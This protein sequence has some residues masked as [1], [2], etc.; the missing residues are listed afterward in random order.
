V[1]LWRVTGDERYLDG[2]RF[3]LE[4]RG[5]AHSVAAFRFDA[6][7]PF[8]IYNDLAYRQDHRPVVEQTRAVGHAVRATYMF[9]GMT[10]VATLLGL[11]AWSETLRSVWRDVTDRR[12]YLTGGLGSQGRT[13]AFGDDY[14][15]PNRRAYAE[16]CAS[17]GGV[18]WN[19]RMFL[20]EGDAAYL[21]VLERTLYN[22]LLSGVSLAGD[23]FFY[24]NPLASDGSVERSAYFDVACCPA[25]LSRLLAQLPGLV[26]AQRGA[27]VFVNLFV[28]SEAR[29]AVSGTVVRLRQETDYPWSGRV[30][31]RVDPERP[32]ELTLSVRIPAWARGLASP[33][34]LYRYA[35][36]R[37]EAPRLRLNG[38][39]LALAPERG[40]MCVT[41]RWQAGDR[42]ELELPM[43]VRRV[44]A[45]D[46]V[47][48]DR[49]RRAIE[50]GPL[51]YAVE[52]IDNGGHATSLQLPLEAPLQHAFR[53]DLLGGVEVVSGGGLVAVP[54]YAWANRGQ[55]EMAVW[56]RYK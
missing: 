52:A 15:L 50:R 49:G 17:V 36:A 18:L 27:E 16:T 31:L 13:E 6:E 20:R 48:E 45:H 51:V 55:G 56:L 41:R 34:G 43:P 12:L 35:G 47:A 22:G 24:Q 8:S 14:A 4:Q 39:D 28:G 10:D 53:R 33:G 2:A 23:T 40:F 25:N 9:T 38:G 21:D 32:T 11:E 26:Y 3:F 1:K 42:L 5:R 54:Y 7:D 46:A 19:H 29:L 37:P 44:L 30:T